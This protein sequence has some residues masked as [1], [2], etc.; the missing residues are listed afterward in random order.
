MLPILWVYT[1][2]KLTAE[3]VLVALS[4]TCGAGS[5]YLWKQ[6]RRWLGVTVFVVGVALMSA[7]VPH[8]QI[9]VG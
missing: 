2:S 9:S 3:L 8:W 6:E 1:L 5:W 7:I 4:I